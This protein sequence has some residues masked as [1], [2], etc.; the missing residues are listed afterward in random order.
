MNTRHNLIMII[1][2]LEMNIYDRKHINFIFIQNLNAV[3]ATVLI[4][5]VWFPSAVS[6]RLGICL[7]HS[8]KQL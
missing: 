3:C 5:A 6:H 4:G 7:Y 8:V 2:K 1:L